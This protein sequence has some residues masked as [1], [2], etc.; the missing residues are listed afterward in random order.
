MGELSRAVRGGCHAS[1]EPCRA[2][3]NAGANRCG[4]TDREDSGTNPLVDDLQHGVDRT[5]FGPRGT[6]AM[7]PV[8]RKCNNVYENMGSPQ[9]VA[10]WYVKR[11]TRRNL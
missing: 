5:S 6:R 4:L 11:V 2:F 8:S 9:N 1:Q 7:Y 10:V 3:G